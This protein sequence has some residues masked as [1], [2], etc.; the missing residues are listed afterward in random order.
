M[1]NAFRATSATAPQG[2]GEGHVGLTKFPRGPQSHRPLCSVQPA[3]PHTEALDISLDANCCSIL[4]ERKL[5]PKAAGTVC[6]W[7][8]RDEGAQGHLNPHL[9]CYTSPNLHPLPPT[10][11]RC[12]PV[13]QPLYTAAQHAAPQA[14]P[15]A[16]AL[17]QLQ[18]SSWGPRPKPQQNQTFPGL[19][20]AGSVKGR[21][22][23][24]RRG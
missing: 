4:Q 7:P 20:S 23:Q 6:S 22:P 19:A 1:S 15:G 3:Q 10:R 13:G 17:I 11:R 14:C 21:R 12:G 16:Q 18:V 24:R 5:R 8:H 9:F 2:P